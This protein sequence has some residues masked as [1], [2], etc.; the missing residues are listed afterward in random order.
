MHTKVC[1]SHESAQSGTYSQKFSLVRDSFARLS[2]MCET[3]PNAPF[4]PDSAIPPRAHT[5]H[6][7]GE[8]T[9]TPRFRPD[10]SSPFYGRN[11]HQPSISPIL[12]HPAASPLPAFYGRKDHHPTISPR[13]L[14]TILWAKPPP[15]L[16]FAQTQ[17]SRREPT[18][19]ILWAK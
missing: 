9:I 4:R 14:F 13:L 10:S 11:R 18:P 19:C 2:V 6:F 8:M 3:A 1:R 16:H 7:M 5:L 12:S 17:P 15:T